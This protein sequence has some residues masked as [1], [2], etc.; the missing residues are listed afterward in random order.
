MVKNLKESSKKLPADISGPYLTSYKMMIASP[1]IIAAVFSLGFIQIAANN[2]QQ[3]LANKAKESPSTTKLAP[4]PLVTQPV[5][6]VLGAQPAAPEPGQ[7]E[8]SGND[9]SNTNK[10]DAI[11]PSPTN[12]GKALQ[13]AANGQSGSKNES[14]QATRR[15]VKSDDIK[16][17]P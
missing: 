12:A 9:A 2:S 3:E 6:P 17:N 15:A 11:G 1:L 10:A 5:I 16:Q 8:I 13:G 14:L 7:T 4:L